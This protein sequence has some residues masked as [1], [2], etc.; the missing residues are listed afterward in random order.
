MKIKCK[1]KDKLQLEALDEMGC[2]ERYRAGPR[3]SGIM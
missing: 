1:T 3:G 2:G